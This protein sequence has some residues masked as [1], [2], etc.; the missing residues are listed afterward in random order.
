MI[1][2]H[3]RS[4]APGRAV[5]CINLGLP[6][7]TAS[8]LSEPDHPFP[9]PDVHERLERAL[10]RTK[11]DLVVACYGMN[12]GIY[13]PFSEERFAAYRRG[14]DRLIEE[15]EAAGARLVL[16]TP[17]PF[18]PVPLRKSGKLRPKDAEKHAWFAAY[19]GYDDV[20]RRYATWLRARRG[21]VEM[22]VDI[23]APVVEY[24]K[25]RRSEDPE[26]TLAS[27]GIHLNAQGHR[28]IAHAVLERW[29][30]TPRDIPEAVLRLSAERE[31]ILRHAW[32]S[33]VG[34][35]RPGI[36]EGLPIEEARTRAAA[37]ETRIRDAVEDEK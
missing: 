23:R 14:I 16:L 25:R 5:D 30:E 10:A 26:F 20:L 37:I 28:L 1:D 19:D 4:V 11:P 35:Q 8:G 15:V 22:V 33:H 2:A 3:Y 34:H 7:E 17:P 13:H 21:R 18:D 9:R 27:D 32:L 36:A 24:L 29:G 31:K 6:S 12:D